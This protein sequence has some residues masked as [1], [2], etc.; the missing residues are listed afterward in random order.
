MR[1]YIAGP[2]SNADPAVVAT[3]VLRAI[4]AGNKVAEAGC[5]V[6]IPH[7]NHYWHQKFQHPYEFWMKQDMA[8]LETCKIMIVV[9]EESGGVKREIDMARRLNIQ[10]YRGVA[11][12]LRDLAIA[13]DAAR[14]FGI[15]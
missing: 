14:D 13:K 15:T 5:D 3:N 4:E 1:V 12:F 2:Y 7:L 8:W 11:S 10:V 9:G 6:F